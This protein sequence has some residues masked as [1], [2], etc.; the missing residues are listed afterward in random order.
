MAKA[1][2]PGRAQRAAV[3]R[4][5]R[6]LFAAINAEFKAG[7]A[8]FLG[9]MIKERLSGAG[10]ASL[11]RR[12]GQL[13][14]SLDA[15]VVSH[16]RAVVMTA[17]IGGGVPYARIHEHGGVITPKKGKY[18]AIPLG[19]AK[20]R[21]GDSR[22]SGPRQWP[23]KLTFIKTKFGKKLLAEVL[24]KRVDTSR[25]IATFGTH[26][27]QVRKAY[28]QT[29]GIPGGGTI[30]QK[31]YRLE[32]QYRQNTATVRGSKVVRAFRDVVVGRTNTPGGTFDIVK[33]T[34]IRPIFLLVESVTIRP[35]LNFRTTFEDEA[36]KTLDNVRA[37]VAK[38]NSVPLR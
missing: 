26:A 27:V 29:Y 36:R 17:F 3:E 35:R 9:R 2:D 38:I 10:P 24:T 1:D 21:G 11:A 23:G 37:A 5:Q 4:R 8:R 7:K 25:Q 16:P 30:R 31:L 18:L 33:R 14:R 12:T 15:V 20:T 28:I 34:S 19:P 13:A 22:V 32:T 6:E